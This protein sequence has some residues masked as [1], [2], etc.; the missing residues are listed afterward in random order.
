MIQKMSLAVQGNT[1]ADVFMLPHDRLGQAINA[2]VI[3]PNLVSADR[4]K[5]DFMPAAVQ[6]ATGPDGKVY[7]FPLS[8][9][10]YGLFY[11]KKYF[12]T[13]PKTFEEIIKVGKQMTDRDKN[14]YGIFFDVANFYF[15]YCFLAMDGGYVFGDN[16]Y[17]IKD[18]GLNNKG[19]IQGLQ[20]LLTLKPISFKIPPGKNQADAP[21]TGLFGEGKI[22][23]IITGPWS[24]DNIRKSK[25]KFGI[26]PL[27]T[28]NGKHP[29]S[30]SGVRLF[31]VNP[32]SK[33][34]KAAQLFAK[35]CTSDRMLLKR[36]EITAQIPPVKALLKNKKITDNPFVKPFLEQANYAQ[37]MPS[38]PEMNLIWDPSIAA[39][40]DAWTGKATPKEALDNL[41]KVIKQQIELQSNN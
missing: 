37:P 23:T 31:A 1:G 25:V 13:A 10:T 7:G 40:S 16:G 21:M 24:I 19:S 22:A 20:S 38:V 27:P 3:M 32:G 28:F 14:Q 12:P 35:F 4:I 26:A 11:N 29:V 34:K 5:K 33:Y 41:V 6:A 2:G 17:N 15:T 30:F 8:I 18:I 9:E 36:Y 39:F